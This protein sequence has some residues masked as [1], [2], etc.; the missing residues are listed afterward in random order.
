MDLG[1]EREPVAP[2]V[3]LLL[4]Y[5]LRLALLLGGS[6]LATQLLL[7]DLALGSDTEDGERLVR[8][9]DEKEGLGRVVLDVRYR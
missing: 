7:L 6:L 8:G 2:R 4:R 5:C 3:L 1:P 9:E